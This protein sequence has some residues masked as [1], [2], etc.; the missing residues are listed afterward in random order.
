MVRLWP[1]AG[2]LSS[3]LWMGLAAALM[4]HAQASRR[5]WGSLLFGFALTWLTGA[6]YWGWLR[7]EPFLHLPVEALGL[8][9]AL[10]KL[11]HPLLRVGSAFYLGSLLG[12]VVTDVYFYLVQVIPHW[13]HLMQVEPTQAGEI[14]RA[15]LALVQTPWG[16]LWA[17][18]LGLFLLGVGLVSLR[19]PSLHGYA[20]SGA[21]LSTL[22]VDG[23]FWLAARAA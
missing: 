2:L 15:A 4:A 21:V 1:W 5:V 17:L 22:L 14:L 10:W 13:R 6:M 11:R 3:V 18:G 20:F 19:R 23:L 9:L 16:L 12:T 7:W 8:P